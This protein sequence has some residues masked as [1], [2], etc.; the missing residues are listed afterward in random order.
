MQTNGYWENNAVKLIHSGKAYFDLL[1]YN[2]RN[3]ALEI[4]I[5][6]YIFKDDQTGLEIIKEMIQAS[7]RRC[8]IFLLLDGIASSISHEN[9]K[10]LKEAGVYIHFFEPF[11]SGK[12]YYFGRRLHQKIC[13]FDNHTALVGGINIADRYNDILTQK[14]WLDYAIEIKG[15]A[16]ND[17]SKYCKSWWEDKVKLE[18]E[19][20]HDDPNKYKYGNSKVR[21]RRNDWTKH[22]NEISLS[23]LEMF[24]N[25]EHEIVILCSYFL[26]GKTIRR[27][28]IRAAERG[29]NIKVILAGR[30]DI[31]ISKHAERWLY[32]WL[33]RQ[34]IEIYE[35]QKNILHGKLA[36]CD[37]KWMTIGSY[38][39]NNLSTYVSI[40][41]N[42]DIIDKEFCSSVREEMKSIIEKDCTK[43]NVSTNRI[44]HNPLVQFYR[45]LCYFFL[46]WV[47]RFT[48]FYFKRSK[49]KSKTIL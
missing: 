6:A 46:V 42:V 12:S 38:N 1:K 36:I 22:L 5:H 23:Y 34:K 48:T 13:V 47:L 26:P 18:F 44:K 14:A 20:K 11:L 2:I 24:R 4:M 33:F 15:N 27:A 40:E 17:I 7:K 31:T 39:M 16:V 28:I 43:I 30:S 35:Y 21:V 25:A 29:V 41:C 8:K 49:G 3:S 10:R 32:D 37:E 19:V 45:W 9:L